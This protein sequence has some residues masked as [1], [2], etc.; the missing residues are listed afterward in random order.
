M[1][2]GW[3][4]LRKSALS[5]FAGVAP[6]VIPVWTRKFCAT[7]G[8]GGKF[9]AFAADEFDQQH[10]ERMAK[11]SF[12]SRDVALFHYLA[13]GSERDWQPRQGFSPRRYLQDN[14]DVLFAGYEPFAHYCRFGRYEGRGA[15]GVGDDTGDPDPPS[16]S[17][18][19]SRLRP[20][21]APPVVDVVIPVYGNRALTL[22]AIDSVL[23]A[24]DA[25]PFELIVVDDASP[26]RML[27]RDLETLAKAGLITLIVNEQNRGFVQT[28]NRGL[29]LHRDRDVVLLNSDTRVFGDWLTRLLAALNTANDIG[30]ATPLSNAATILSYPITLRDN[31]MR[32]T[33]LAEIDGICRALDLRPISIPTA[34]GFCMAVRRP[35]LDQVGVFDAGN[36]GRGYGEENDFCLRAT[37]KGWRHVAATNIL[38]WH[39]GGASFEG[40]RDARIQQAQA[41]L[42][43]LHPAYHARIRAF[44][45]LDPLKLVRGRLD[46]ARGALDPRPKVLE[47]EGKHRKQ[48][49]EELAVRLIPDIGRFC[50]QWRVVI[51]QLRR[52]PNLPRLHGAEAAQ[53]LARLL[54]DLSIQE[55]RASSNDRT[56]SILQQKLVIEA[57]RQGIP[58]LEGDEA[59]ARA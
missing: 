38:V 53:G 11:Q 34:V 36:F 42:Q 10:Y 14:P 31:V 24:G 17:S 46:A 27:A 18:M 56:A 35:C 25:V 12:R 15:A 48:D 51:P 55:V 44:F 19:L 1:R 40:E 16:L 41:V 8:L 47:F 3:T 9:G 7:A 57:R 5:A 37:A 54:A 23:G 29:L 28:A 59:S 45:E 26:D 21:R 20:P 33:E 50:G 39:E 22:R 13:V 58:V 4:D 6:A 30:T 52:L 32:T 49:R 43:R 2:D